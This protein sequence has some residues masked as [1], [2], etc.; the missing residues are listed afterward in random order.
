MKEVKVELQKES[1]VRNDVN[2]RARSE[3][4]MQCWSYLVTTALP[5]TL[6]FSGSVSPRVVVSCRQAYHLSSFLPDKMQNGTEGRGVHIAVWPDGNK[7]VAKQ[8]HPNSFLI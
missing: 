1:A 4:T 5:L 8:G 6:R 7:H 3:V 2:I